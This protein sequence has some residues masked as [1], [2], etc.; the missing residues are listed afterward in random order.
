MSDGEQFSKDRLKQYLLEGKFSNEALFQLYVVQTK[1]YLFQTRPHGALEE[2]QFRADFSQ[3][4][5]LTLNEIFI[6]GSAQTG[7]SIKPSA[8]LRG[9]DQEFLK[10]NVRKDKSDVDVAI[11]SSTYF[12]KMHKAIRSFTYGFTK[13]WEKNA[14]YPYPSEIRHWI[15]PRV[16]ANFYHYLAKGWFRPDLVPDDFQLEFTKVV[17][18]WKNRL[19]RKVSVGI[20]KEW[21]NLKEY[22]LQAFEQLKQSALKGSI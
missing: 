21:F 18:N 12:E 1:A 16:D 5:G 11:V 7:F 10:S 15:V 8:P 2:M 13:A 4:T 3:A 17:S 6:V 20:Y 19:D 22:Q 14:Y 9:F